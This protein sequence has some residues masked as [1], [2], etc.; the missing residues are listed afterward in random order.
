MGR[1]RTKKQLTVGKNYD[2]KCIV[3]DG[4]SIG[5][6]WLPHALLMKS[7]KFYSQIHFLWIHVT[8]TTHNLTAACKCGG[9]GSGA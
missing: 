9:G 3:N 7:H 5:I 2:L 6:P 4:C 1:R 8:Y